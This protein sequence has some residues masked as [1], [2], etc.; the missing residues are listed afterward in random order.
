MPYSKV[1]TA[2]SPVAQTIVASV[3]KSDASRTS[4]MTGGV[5]SEGKIDGSGVG[6]SSGVGIGVEIGVG[7]GPTLMVGNGVGVSVDKFGV[8]V[9][10]RVGVAKAGV[11]IGVG[12]GVDRFGV[13]VANKFSPS[14]KAGA[15]FI[16]SILATRKNERNPES[17]FGFIL[18]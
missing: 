18:Y 12:T 14:A 17:I 2:N 7:V 4:E 8:A 13:G 16:M 3:G 5:I 15:T 9:G 6:V 11:G 1:E 10:T